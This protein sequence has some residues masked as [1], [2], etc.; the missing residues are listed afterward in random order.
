MQ[1]NT[2]E[3]KIIK[4]RIENQRENRKYIRKY[5]AVIKKLFLTAWF[6]SVP[7]SLLS[8]YLVPNVCYVWMWSATQ[9]N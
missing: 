9:Y 7:S 1:Q 5:N 6:P 8:T 2:I 4:S 3:Q